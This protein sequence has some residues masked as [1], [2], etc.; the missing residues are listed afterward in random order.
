M[1]NLSKNLKTYYYNL[2]PEMKQIILL[3]MLGALTMGCSQINSYFGVKDDSII[4]ETVE[5]LIEAKTG[6]D[7]DLTPGTPER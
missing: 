4:E 3:L 6:L 7:I 5:S 2:D 1:R